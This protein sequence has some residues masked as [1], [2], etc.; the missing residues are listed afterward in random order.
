MGMT[1]VACRTAWI[2]DTNPATMIDRNA[3]RQGG[4]LALRR[5]GNE[6][7][8]TQARPRG[9]ARPWAPAGGG[10]GARVGALKAGAVEQHDATPGAEDLGADD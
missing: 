2:S 9:E 3:S 6:W 5:E 8:I 1:V 10:A 7:A 4:A